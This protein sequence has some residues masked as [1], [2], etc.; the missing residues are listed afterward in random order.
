MGRLIAMLASA[1]LAA[2]ATT[3][4]GRTQM[5]LIP[6]SQINQMGVTAFAQLRENAKPTRDAQLQRRAECI[7]RALIEVLPQEWQR[8][9]WEVVVFEDDS[10]NAFALP[11]G[12]VGVHTGLM[13]MAQNQDQLAAVIGHELGHVVFRHGGERVSQQFAASAALE[14]AGAYAGREGSSEAS[15]QV[16]GLLGVGAQVGVLLPFSRKHEREADRYGQQL[17][18]EAG[19]DP[20]AAPALWRLMEAQ[21]RGARPPA[22][23]STHP[24]P[25]ARINDLDGRVEGL[26]P[27]YEQARA[28]G[29]RPAC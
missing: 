5:L 25:A 19:F 4:T 18:A 6:D 26:R 17:M 11:G 15:K 23:L 14:L 29:R 3:P 24:D 10:V 20:I 21:S 16:V 28:Q 27:V 8:L 1:A 22:L 7:T 12:K 9:P 2:C 13:R